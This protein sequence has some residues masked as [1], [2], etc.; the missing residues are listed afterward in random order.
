M[1]NTLMKTN[2]TPDKTRRGARPARSARRLSKAVAKTSVMELAP[3]SPSLLKLKSIVVPIDFS[4]TANKAL[5]YAMRLAD[6]FGGRL[7]VIHVVQPMAVPEFAAVSL[8]L[9]NDN[10]KKA[11]LARLD[12]LLKRMKVP[13]HLV[14]RRIV[15]FGT[16]FAEITS[17][18]KSLKADVIVLT[19]HGYTGLKHA[20]L[21]STAERVVRHAPCPVLTVRDKAS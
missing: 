6:R 9:E 13:S 16:P 7:T 8:L 4:P 1:T 12:T 20:L 18:A 11:A 5:A 19:T 3:T 14:D 17:A 10:V 2:S 15:R 21:G